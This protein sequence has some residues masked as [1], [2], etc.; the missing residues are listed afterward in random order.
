[1]TSSLLNINSEFKG[2]IVKDLDFNYSQINNKK[3]Y[4]E[5]PK[6]IINSNGLVIFSEKY[7]LTNQPLFHLWE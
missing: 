2:V 6:F 1:M 5:F 3:E 7:R 4:K